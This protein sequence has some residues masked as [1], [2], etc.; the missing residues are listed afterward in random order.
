MIE[1]DPTQL[2]DELVNIEVGVEIAGIDRGRGQFCKEGAPFRLDRGQ[3]TANRIVRVGVV[4]FEKTT[5]NRT[6]TM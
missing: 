2:P 4:E 3:T 6:A 1:I 5:G